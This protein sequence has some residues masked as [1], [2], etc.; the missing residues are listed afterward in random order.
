MSQQLISWDFG[1]VFFWIKCWLGQIQMHLKILNR[2]GMAKG[3]SY[4][5][6]SLFTTKNPLSQTQ[7]VWALRFDSYCL[8][9][10]IQRSC[11]QNRLDLHFSRFNSKIWFSFTPWNSKTFSLN[12]VKF[13]FLVPCRI[14]KNKCSKRRAHIRTRSH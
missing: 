14:N 9:V 5:S 7:V 1:I 4:L 2:T 11:L 6:S 10:R 13:R 8:Y 12:D 3:Y